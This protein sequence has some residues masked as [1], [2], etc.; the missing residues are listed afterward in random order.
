V[1][2]KL[3][4]AW[5][6][7]LSLLIDACN[8]PGTPPVPRPTAQS[9]SAVRFDMFVPLSGSI[10]PVGEVIDLRQY[11]QVVPYGSPITI[12]NGTFLVNGASVGATNGEYYPLAGTWTA[13]NPG[14]YYIQAKVTLSNGSTA[15]S[16]PARICVMSLI[17]SLPMTWAG[18]LGPCPI[19]TQIPNS[20]ISGDLA[21]S[22]VAAPSVI[23]FS[24]ACPFEASVTFIAHVNDPQDQVALVGVSIRIP[25]SPGVSG[26][27]YLNWITTRPI[28]QKEY[29]ATMQFAP[30]ILTGVSAL[31]WTVIPWGRIGQ[32]LRL[33]EGDIPVQLVDCNPPPRPG[34]LPPTLTPTP[35]VLKI[36]P[37][38]PT[39]KPKKEGD[40]PAPPPPACYSKPCP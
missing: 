19:A 8:Y 12:S 33:V 26:G 6:C 32:Q 38:T 25:D 14:E 10:H 1:K 27:Q 13:S 40:L 7:T 5:L 29:R 31:H 18:Y 28:N 21:V 35:V 4:V 36:V 11:I 23:H 34:I 24:A 3:M 16:E 20:P 37:S 2:T 9:N 39:K 17:N 15:I 22:V 30:D